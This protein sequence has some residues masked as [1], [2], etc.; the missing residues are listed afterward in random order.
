V[1]CVTYRKCTTTE[2]DAAWKT[3]HKNAA[4]CAARLQDG[5]NLRGNRSS[6]D[7]S[8][9]NGVSDVQA[10]SA[11]CTGNASCQYFVYEKSGKNA[12]RCWLKKNY[13][14][15]QTNS[16]VV[17][18]FRCDKRRRL[19]TTLGEE[20]KGNSEDDVKELAARAPIF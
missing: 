6:E 8:H 2:G 18:G 5:K 4:G 15:T 17:S 1:S 10:C 20:M 9:Y 13:T 16:N 19:E 11:L 12:R 7:V 3:V 14:D